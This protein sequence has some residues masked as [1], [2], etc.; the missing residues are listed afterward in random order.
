MTNSR[1][2]LLAVVLCWFALPTAAGDAY[3]LNDPGIRLSAQF[4]TMLGTGEPT[5]D[6]PSFGFTGYY[7]WTDRFGNHSA[8]EVTGRVDQHFADWTYRDRVS[9]RQVTLDDYSAKGVFIGYQYRF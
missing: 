5:N 7:P 3:G 2:V 4:G 1:K 8:L 9:G 6:M